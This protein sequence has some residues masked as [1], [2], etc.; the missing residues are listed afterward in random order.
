MTLDD[1]LQRIPT[2][3]Q[4]RVARTKERYNKRVREVLRQ[5]TGLRLSRATGEEISQVRIALLPGL[6]E[7]LRGKRPPPEVA[8]AVLLAP[9]RGLITEL[10]NSSK[11]TLQ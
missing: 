8:L 4:E 5:G 3:T 6:P 11:A 7:P 2:D 1:L 10:R 9:W